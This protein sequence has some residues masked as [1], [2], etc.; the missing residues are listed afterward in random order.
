L[1]ISIF[2]FLSDMLILSKSLAPVSYR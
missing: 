2:M 1:L